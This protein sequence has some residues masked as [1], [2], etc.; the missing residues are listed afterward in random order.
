MF[1]I[2]LGARNKLH[3]QSLQL[4]WTMIFW[5]LR[6]FVVMSS[7]YTETFI[8]DP[9]FHIGSLHSVLRNIL[10]YTFPNKQ[11]IIP[12]RIPWFQAPTHRFKLPPLSYQ[13]IT[14]II[15]RM[16]SSTSPST[17]DQISII[18]FKRCPYLR[19]LLTKFI[20]IIR[21]SGSIPSIWKNTCSILIHKKGST[22]LE[23]RPRL[24][25]LLARRLKTN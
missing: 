24:T 6:T 1:P 23:D 7:A 8:A 11:F 17:L 3:L 9:C 22:C 4:A 15:W 14:A 19:S 18:C 12:S 21:N 13:K 20:G 16:T 25:I 5:F 2:F 10:S